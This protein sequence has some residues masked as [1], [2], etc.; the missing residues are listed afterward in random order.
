MSGKIDIK[1]K[2]NVREILLQHLY[3]H[4]FFGGDK[5]SR[6]SEA[7][8]TDVFFADMKDVKAEYFKVTYADLISHLS[9]VEEAII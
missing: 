8:L 7:L 4:L 5:A 9:S 1:T 2:K 6:D 3:S